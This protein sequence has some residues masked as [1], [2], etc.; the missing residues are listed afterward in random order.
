MVIIDFIPPR[1]C[2]NSTLALSVLALAGALRKC[3]VRRLD[4]LSI[5][6]GPK[7]RSSIAT[8]FR[9]VGCIVRLP[10]A[11]FYGKL[12]LVVNVSPLATM[13]LVL[14]ATFPSRFQ[15]LVDGEWAT[16]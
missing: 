9:F 13:P 15:S 8:F 14:L 1:K 3:A 4:G 11:F 16:T 7:S 2:Y 5:F 12:V 10:S 6:H